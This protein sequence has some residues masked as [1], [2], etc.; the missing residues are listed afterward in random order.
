MSREEA[1]ELVV[2]SDPYLDRVLESMLAE[3]ASSKPDVSKYCQLTGISEDLVKKMQIGFV[4]GLSFMD[5]M[6]VVPGADDPHA[7]FAM[8]VVLEGLERNVQR[9]MTLDTCVTSLAWLTLYLLWKLPPWY[10]G[11]PSCAVAL[12]FTLSP[13]ETAPSISNV[14]S[15]F[16]KVAKVMVNDPY[17]DAAIGER[18]RGILSLCLV[19]TVLR[20]HAWFAFCMCLTAAPLAFVAVT[21]GMKP[22]PSIVSSFKIVR[23]LCRSGLFLAM[24]LQNWRDYSTLALC[25]RA[26]APD[27]LI[28]LFSVSLLGSWVAMGAAIHYAALWCIPTPVVVWRRDLEATRPNIYMVLWV[29][30]AVATHWYLWSVSDP[31]WLPL[32]ALIAVKAWDMLPVKVQGVVLGASVA[33]G[34]VL[35]MVFVTGLEMVRVRVFKG[36][37]MKQ[38][39]GR[40][41]RGPTDSSGS[42][43]DR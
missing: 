22:N 23:V 20:G 31:F 21:S 30:V 14:K 17:N 33:V 25:M 37:P 9:R 10:I 15:G 34:A 12:I 6:M 11:V 3:D 36:E 41:D 32:H 2:L 5:G 7:Q 40:G 28:S 4:A 39:R 38:R 19:S 35:F 18:C 1:Q 42:D 27:T 29:C 43:S 24:V 13:V 16:I 8:S 26:Y